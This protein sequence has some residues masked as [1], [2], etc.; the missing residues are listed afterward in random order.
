MRPKAW[1]DGGG[2]RG[3]GEGDW[4]RGVVAAGDFGYP[5][6][7]LEGFQFDLLKQINKLFFVIFNRSI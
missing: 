1:V 5:V 2:G 4:G 7:R 3:E 6:Q